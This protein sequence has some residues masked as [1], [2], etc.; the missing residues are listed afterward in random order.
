MFT[1]NMKCKGEVVSP[2][3]GDYL[4]KEEQKT[5]E[6]LFPDKTEENKKYR[7]K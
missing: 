6:E 2:T 4:V 7:C 3:Y 1:N 5:F